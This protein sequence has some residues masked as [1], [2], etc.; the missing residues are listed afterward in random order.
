MASSKQC[1]ACV[2]Q[3]MIERKATQVG[4]DH[5][6]LE[7]L[8]VRLAGVAQRADLWSDGTR[9]PAKRVARRTRGER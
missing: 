9:R 1:S 3:L 5:R 8:S 4:A 6:D 7:A 2:A